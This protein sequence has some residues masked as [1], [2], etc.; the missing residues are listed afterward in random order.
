MIATL[1]WTRERVRYLPAIIATRRNPN[2]VRAGAPAPVGAG[3]QDAD[4]PGRPVCHRK[5]RRSADQAV[6]QGAPLQLHT[7]RQR[8]DAVCRTGQARR[9]QSILL[10]AARPS[11]LPCSGHHASHSRRAPAIPPDRRQAAGALTSAIALARS[12]DPA[13]LGLSRSELQAP[14]RSLTRSHLRPMPPISQTASG[15]TAVLEYRPAETLPLLGAMLL[16]FVRLC[17]RCRPARPPKW[18][19]TRVFPGTEA[20][21]GERQTVCW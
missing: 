16:G 12:T 7:R 18:R 14:P 13:R 21:P 1:W 20:K 5:A 9:C 10:H 8:R 11:Q 6:D 19:K 17:R 3:D 4:R 15:S 2:P